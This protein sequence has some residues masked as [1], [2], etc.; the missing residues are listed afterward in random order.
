MAIVGG[1]DSKT[2]SSNLLRFGCYTFI[3]WTRWTLA[4]CLSWW[5][6]HRHYHDY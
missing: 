5:Q 2:H 1:D 4:M 6:H 3:S